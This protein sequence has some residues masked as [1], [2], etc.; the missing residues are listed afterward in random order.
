MHVLVLI[1]LF[2]YF[3][4]LACDRDTHGVAHSLCKRDTVTLLEHTSFL[5]GVKWTHGY[6]DV[7]LILG[8]ICLS[9]GRI[10]LAHLFQLVMIS[11]ACILRIHLCTI[12]TPQ[13][14]GNL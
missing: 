10:A 2:I 1:T 13:I 11:F 3:I 8:V 6:T 12:F 5:S 14:R 7:L 9:S 4:W